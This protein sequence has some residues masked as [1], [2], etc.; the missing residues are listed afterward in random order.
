MKTLI[1][2][3]LLSVFSFIGKAQ[4]NVLMK[5]EEQI[6]QLI[7]SNMSGIYDETKYSNKGEKIMFFKFPYEN[8]LLAAE[9]YIADQGV[10]YYCVYTYKNDDLMNK[11]VESI[12]VSPGFKRVEGTFQF[13]NNGGY[14]VEFGRREHNEMTI[15]FFL[16]EK[17][18]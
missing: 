1:I 12:K 16:S 3:L 8:P 9:C 5:N 6:K 15:T 13:V 4:V 7:A 10:C 18:D 11:Y 14:T 17:T 2:I